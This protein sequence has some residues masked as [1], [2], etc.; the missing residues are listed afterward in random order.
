MNIIL[1]LST[2]LQLNVSITPQYFYQVVHKTSE[3]SSTLQNNNY[4]LKGKQSKALFS[5]IMQRYFITTV[6]IL[7]GQNFKW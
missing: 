4:L 6:N 3:K 7:F 1:K 2:F 5:D